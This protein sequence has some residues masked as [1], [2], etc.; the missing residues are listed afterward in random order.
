MGVYDEGGTRQ[1]LLP[2]FLYWLLRIIIILGN[3]FELRTRLGLIVY[4]VEQR[5]EGRGKGHTLFDTSAFLL[6]QIDEWRSLNSHLVGLQQRFSLSG[7]LQL[8]L[9]F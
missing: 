2:I 6:E 5:G 8:K 7:Y 4:E 1:S 9:W 3:M